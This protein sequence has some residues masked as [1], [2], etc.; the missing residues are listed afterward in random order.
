M[1]S[2]KADDPSSR[3]LRGWFVVGDMNYL[4]HLEE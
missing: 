3:I 4:Q 2:K 1:L